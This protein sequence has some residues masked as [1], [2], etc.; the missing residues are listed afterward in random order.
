ML[1][2]AKAIIFAFAIFMVSVADQALARVGG[3][4]QI[5][6][7]M[8][9]AYSILYCCPANDYPAL[10][11]HVAE[12][13]DVFDRQQLGHQD[14]IVRR[15]LMELEERAAQQRDFLAKSIAGLAASLSTLTDIIEVLNSK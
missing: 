5:V 2:V 1:E 13:N 4:R 12:P 8:H 11:V 6:S 10:N 7:R 15:E 3:D 9:Y 14:R